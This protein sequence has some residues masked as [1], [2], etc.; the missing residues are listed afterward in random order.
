MPLEQDEGEMAG[1]PPR[2][3]WVRQAMAAT[4]AASVLGLLAAG[5][6]FDSVRIRR[7]AYKPGDPKD[8]RYTIVGQRPLSPNSES[9]CVAV[10]AG[11]VARQAAAALPG[12]DG[13]SASRE[14]AQRSFWAFLDYEEQAGASLFAPL[15]AAARHYPGL[16]DLP[17][18]AD[19]VLPL[20]YYVAL[21]PASQRRI[22]ALIDRGRALVLA[23]A[24]AMDAFYKAL[25]EMDSLDYE[26]ARIIWS[27]AG[28]SVRGD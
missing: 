6:R 23:N 11:L 15:V 16:Q 19:S 7:L 18:I 3:T 27:N 22:N 12:S 26:E 9:L 25:L 14:A 24:A 17:T 1:K 20:D 28:C 13:D 4:S 8:G 5:W 21:S 10:V 2:P